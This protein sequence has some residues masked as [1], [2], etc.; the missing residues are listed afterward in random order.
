MADDDDDGGGCTKTDGAGDRVEDK[1]DKTDADRCSRQ[2]Y[3]RLCAQIA[4]Q[5]M[6]HTGVQVHTDSN[7]SYEQY[8][9]LRPW[10]D[11]PRG[12]NNI[13]IVYR[14]QII[15]INT[16]EL[17]EDGQPP[18]DDAGSGY[19]QGD[20]DNT[21]HNQARDAD[22]AEDIRVCNEEIFV[23]ANTLAL[24]LPQQQ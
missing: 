9:Q 11:S 5:L 16:T 6:Q 14:P 20:N 23:Y 3:H 8:C 15:V 2:A 22:K 1:T 10:L 12:E 17:I 21:E 18:G 24:G 13:N 4:T 19:A 7:L